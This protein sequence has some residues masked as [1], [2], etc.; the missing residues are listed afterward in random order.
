MQTT[1]APTP[2][3]T[4]DEVVWDKAAVCAFF[5]GTKPLNASSLYRGIAEG[6]YPKPFHPTPKLSRWLP[7][8]CRA[9]RDALIANRDP[10]TPAANRVQS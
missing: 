6:R 8:E 4:T 9:A 10:I 3:A 5:G 1:D 2:A 7:S